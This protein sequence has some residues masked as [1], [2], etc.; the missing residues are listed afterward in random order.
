MDG[1]PATR[2]HGIAIA[3]APA[4]FQPDQ[5]EL[6]QK[7]SENLHVGRVIYGDV[8]TEERHR[9]AVERAARITSRVANDNL[10][11]IRKTIVSPF[12]AAMAK[13]LIASQLVW[14][15]LTAKSIAYQNEREV[16]YVIMNVRGKFDD[17][18]KPLGDK[19]D[20]EASVPLKTAGNIKEIFDRTAG[21][22]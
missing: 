2:A 14:N 17:L 4:L 22:R 1:V 9:C 16:R 3:F 19:Y 21:V 13:E 8:A 6:K 11:V 7:A 18:R 12:L 20:I 5:T 10:N 15:C